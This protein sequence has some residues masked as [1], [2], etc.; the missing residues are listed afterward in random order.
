MQGDR[1]GSALVPGERQG[2]EKGQEN[3]KIPDN[4]NQSPEGSLEDAETTNVDNTP[5]EDH[6]HYVTGAKLMTIFV[7]LVLASFLMLLDSSIVSTAIPAISDEFHALEDV[8]WYSAAYNLGS[9]ALQPLTGKI[10]KC[11]CLKW[12]FLTFFVV[13]EIGSVLCGAAQSSNMLIIGRAIAG[14]GA[15]GLLSGSIIIIS[16]CVPLHRRPTLIGINQ[17]VAQ[18]GTVI[19]PLIGGAFTTGYTW[20]WSFY[21]NLPLGAIVA[22]PIVFL[23]IPE[24]IA[25]DPALKILAK[26]H[27]HLDLL[28]FALLA[29]A[30]IQLL[31]A[32]EY[33]GNKFAWN[34]SQIIGLFCGSGATFIVWVFWN[35]Y[36]GDDA[37]L[38]F[39]IMKRRTVWASALNYSFQMETLFGTSYWLPIYF[40]AVKGVS[41]IL[42]G[43]YMLPTILAQLLF[44]VSAGMLVTRVG[45]VP[46]FSIFAG[47]LIPI[48]CGLFSL[49]Q[50]D[51]STGKWIGYQIIASSGRGAG[52]QMPIVAVQ[53]TVT[54][55]DLPM[56]MAFLLWAQYMGP[57]IFLTLYNLIFNTTLKT[58][59]PQIAPDVD[60]QAIISAGATG[61]R[62]IVDARD[63]PKVLV[64]Y[65]D[66]VDRVFYLVA[67]AGVGGFIAAWGMGW[68]DIRKNNEE[69][70]QPQISEA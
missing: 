39:S 14:A 47:V 2:S 19:A 32:L 56:A 55:E 64:A 21:I 5:K 44:T 1:E 48:G 31:L 59:L 69:P 52:L 54:Q 38:P 60:A 51:T 11:F 17:G 22:V 36:K 27:H 30:V 50:P 63:L 53:N 15:S 43:V 7:A 66:S 10:Y 12:S 28:G 18:L 61:F 67:A 8:G 4:G 6:S 33:G 20:R 24:Q 35:Y 40:Q 49:L 16:S 65:S 57:T 58:V 42:S 46:P 37:L 9:A 25:K 3:E 62:Q 68:Q 41:A 34:S 13:F 45:Y 70:R 26:I 29:P 23:R